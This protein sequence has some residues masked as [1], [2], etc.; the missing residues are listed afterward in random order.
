MVSAAALSAARKAI[1]S[2]YTGHCDI[3]ERCSVR[4]EK[5][6]ITRQSEKVVIHN[7]PCRL[8]FERLSAA[9]QTETAAKITQGL[10][11]FI[12][13]EVDVKSGSKIVVEQNG[14]KTECVAGGE[15]AVY[16]SHQE[17]MLELFKEWA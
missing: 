7:Q 2:A 15:P 12:A 5:T 10:K 8:S 6:K 3:I 14:V 13:P 17:I 1:E 4:D 11:L 9:G 16:F